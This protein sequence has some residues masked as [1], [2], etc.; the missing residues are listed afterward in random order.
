MRN[1][2]FALAMVLGIGCGG[3]KLDG[4]ISELEGYKAKM[5][6]CKDKACT[7]KV[8]ED[9]KK[10]E[11]DKFEPAMKGTKKE[12]VSKD[13]IEKFMTA[14]RAMKDCRRKFM[15]EGTAPAPTP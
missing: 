1:I 7:E 15:D 14:E 4:F 9:Y 3:D 10:W 12:D 8:F 13:K 6:E 2:G 5:C 11:N